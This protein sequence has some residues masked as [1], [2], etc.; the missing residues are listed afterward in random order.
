M[1]T[2][3][4]HREKARAAGSAPTDCASVPTSAEF[5]AQ[6]RQHLAAELAKPCGADASLTNFQ[7]LSA[8]LVE[9]ALK[10]SKDAIQIVLDRMAGRTPQAAAGSD[11][12]AK[13]EYVFGIPRPDHE[14]PSASDATPDEGI[15]TLPPAE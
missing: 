11:A 15:P 5:C 1:S 13:I 4:K 7:A 2:R 10:G 3:T 9:M 12:P 8:K 6:L 14:Q